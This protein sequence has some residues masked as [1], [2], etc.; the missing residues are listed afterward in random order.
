MTESDLEPIR[1]KS[2]LQQVECP[3]QAKSEYGKLEGVS[4]A[5][6]EVFP[7]M[8]GYLFAYNFTG[9]GSNDLGFFGKMGID[10][11]MHRSKR[12]L[13]YNYF[14]PV[15]APH[16]NPDDR[17]H[18]SASS[19]NGCAGKLPSYYIRSYGVARGGLFT[20]GLMEDILDINPVSV[21]TSMFSSGAGDVKC[22]RVTLPVGSNFD[23]CQQSVD[24]F[25]YYNT[26][27]TTQTYLGYQKNFNYNNVPNENTRTAHDARVNDFVNQCYEACATHWDA[28]DTRA[29]NK[30]NC[31][32]DC[33]RIWW[34]E[35]HCIP[36]PEYE[37]PQVKYTTCGAN[38][39]HKK[40]RIPV[41][42]SHKHDDADKPKLDKSKYA[43]HKT[44]VDK[45]NEPFQ[46]HLTTPTSC[47]R[48]NMHIAVGKYV[49]FIALVLAIVLLCCFR[50]R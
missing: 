34:E 49:I 18:C 41:G 24:G 45:L 9:T 4:F 12:L 10:D 13:G 33:Q 5:L 1:R 8:L 42:S 11:E 36:K 30:D 40:Y 46:T 19:D 47:A 14:L 7:E 25:N 27:D 17:I 44:T 15:N 39:G 6:G 32:R 22:Q 21:I 37:S 3:L 43:E 28:K 38:E 20:F 50:R 26:P 29:F 31:R 48:R 23:F 2:I 16:T 35:T